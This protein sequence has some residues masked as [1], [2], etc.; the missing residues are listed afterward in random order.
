MPPSSR[1]I[2][3]ITFLW[4]CFFSAAHFPLCAYGTEQNPDVLQI[5]EKV[6]QKKLAT[7]MASTIEMFL[8]DKDGSQRKRKVR[9]FLK[10]FEGQ[11][12]QIIF[13]QEPAAVKGTGL[14]TFDYTDASAEDE[15]WIYLPAL[16]KVKRISGSNRQGSFMG[17]DFSY[18]DMMQKSHS[19]YN[20]SLI[21]EVDADNHRLWVIQRE[22]RNKDIIDRDG[23]TK[24]L[25][26]IRQDNYV[27]VKKVHWMKNS[28]T[29]KYYEI[30]KLELIDGIWI[31]SVVKAKTVNNGQILH[32]TMLLTS[33]TSVGTEL[34]DDMFTVKRLEQG[35]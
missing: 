2:V 3:K 21:K 13:F 4:L 9:S 11:T 6:K 28:N 34:E 7:T 33:A 24:S 16:H 22:P 15:Q 31:P 18:G 23:Y 19:D 17:S 35:L 12:K 14:L 5:M 26:L 32:Q 20:Y 8:I 27:V 10:Q 1:H 29:L 25:L 30:E